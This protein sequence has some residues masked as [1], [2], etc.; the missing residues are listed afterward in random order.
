MVRAILVRVRGVG[1]LDG[2]D[3]G[4]GTHGAGV[5]GERGG[6][7]DGHRGGKEEG[8]TERVK[9]CPAMN[10]LVVDEGV[11][12]QQQLGDGQMAVE[13][14]VEEC[15]PVE[16]VKVVEKLGG[17][18]QEVGHAIDVAR[19]SSNDQWCEARFIIDGVDGV[20]R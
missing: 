18:L 17:N 10:V 2:A 7:A 4:W 16:M 6:G 9:R 11:L 19:E 8:S 5:V 3:R 14:R 12:L 1:V 13:E 20:Q 15:S